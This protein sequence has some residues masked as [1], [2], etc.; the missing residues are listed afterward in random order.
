M[1]QNHSNSFLSDGMENMSRA[2]H[3]HPSYLQMYSRGRGEMEQPEGEGE[4]VPK[5]ELDFSVLLCSHGYK[6]LET[7][8]G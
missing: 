5:P 3:S 6:D 4:A 7:T 8:A 1:P 2:D